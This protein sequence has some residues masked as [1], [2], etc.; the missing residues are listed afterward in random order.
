MQTRV[1]TT[2]CPS[3]PHSRRLWCT[4]TPHPPQ[5]SRLNTLRPRPLRTFPPSLETDPFCPCFGPP[6]LGHA[7]NSAFHLGGDPFC[8][9]CVSSM[10]L[11]LFVSF[12]LCFGFLCHPGSASIAHSPASL[13][14]LCSFGIV[15]PF[16]GCACHLGTEQLLPSG[17]A[18]Q[19]KQGHSGMFLELCPSPNKHPGISETPMRRGQLPLRVVLC[20]GWQ[21]TGAS[22]IGFLVACLVSLAGSSFSSVLRVD[23]WPWG[24]V[25]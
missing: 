6:C 7:P 21:G 18:L 13:T 24:S 10:C 14:K 20:C 1:P 17:A 4:D 12:C 8:V 16:L 15:I 25:T 9:F 5:K 19:T 23:F 3:L 2:D 11:C 22:P